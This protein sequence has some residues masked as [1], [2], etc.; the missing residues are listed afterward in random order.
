MPNR[1]VLELAES[2]AVKRLVVGNPLTRGLVD[3]FVAG[4]TIESG[5]EAAERLNRGGMRTLLGYLGEHVSQE[6]EADDAAAI[7]VQILDEV[8]RRTPGSHITVKLTQLGLDLSMDDCLQ[9]MEK[10]CA[11]AAEVGSTVA[12]DMESHEHTDRTIDA[13]KALRNSHTNL[14][15]CLQA[16]LKRT[17]SD[18]AALLPLNPA[19]RLCKGAYNEPSD[20]A[21]DRK[22]TGPAFMSILSD[23][24]SA[25]SYTAVATHDHEI[26]RDTLRLSR[27]L[28]V[29]PDR[30]EFQMLY[31]IRRD[32]QKS[33]A[34]LGLGTRVFVA[35]GESWYPYLMRR[36]AERPANLRLFLEALLR[37]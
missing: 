22:A 25:S 21:L 36:L 8:A 28:D 11:K 35:F 16:Y 13:Y 12:I 10:I 26:I 27:E 17:P 23:L 2:A 15:L 14:V 32:L 1:L 19:I 7:Y 5:I 20:I 30:Y 29:A 24:L 31:G 18:V 3:R 4:E 9:R 34:G 37:G 33:L 6:K